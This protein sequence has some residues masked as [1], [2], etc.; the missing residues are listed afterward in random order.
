MLLCDYLQLLTRYLIDTCTDPSVALSAT[1]YQAAESEGLLTICA[2]LSLFA[3]EYPLGLTEPLTVD[4]ATAD[5][6]AGTN[7]QKSR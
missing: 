3:S 2:S 1:T 6:I 4:L 7:S 5:D